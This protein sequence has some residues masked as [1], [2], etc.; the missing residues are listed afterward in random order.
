MEE[1]AQSWKWVS[2]SAFAFFICFYVGRHVQEPLD[3]MQRRILQSTWF[4][5]FFVFCV[6]WVCSDR[7]LKVALGLFAVY[8]VCRELLFNSKSPIQLFPK[9]WQLDLD[10]NKDGLISDS[11]LDTAIQTLEKI[12]KERHSEGRFVMRQ[13]QS[14]RG[15]RGVRGPRV[16]R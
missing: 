5:H 12:R 14:V 16:V 3:P 2:F 13:G 15:V 1:K 8:L 10:K 4:Q 6:C 7:N 9:S 11:E